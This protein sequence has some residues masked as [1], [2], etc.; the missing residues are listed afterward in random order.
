MSYLSLQF[1]LEKSTS[2]SY[3]ST[4]TTTPLPDGLDQSLAGRVDPIYT[5][6]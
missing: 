5:I 6:P 4:Q 2:F 3:T 1:L